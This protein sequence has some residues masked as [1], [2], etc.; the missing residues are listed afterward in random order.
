MWAKVSLAALLALVVAGG[1]FAQVRQAELRLVDP[2]PL[3]VRGTGF[4]P[5]EHVRVVY[6]ARRVWTRSMS[7]SVTGAFTSA[8][9]RVA[10]DVC[11]AKQL[12]AIGS[13]GSRAEA[14]LPRPV[15]ASP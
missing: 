7:A 11:A 6:E 3:T 5:H 15:C 2:E 8:F 14:R 10:L 12:Y 1:S 4:K 9:S 13:L